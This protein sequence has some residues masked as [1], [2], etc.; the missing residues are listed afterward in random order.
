MRHWVF[1]SETPLT[2]AAASPV[3]NAKLLMAL[4]A[5]GAHLDFR[6]L[7]GLT[8]LH[9]A[10]RLGDPSNVK[11]LLSLGASPNC[12]DAQG[13]TPIYHCCLTVQSSPLVAEA[14]L[15]DYAELGTVDVHRN[16]EIHQVSIKFILIKFTKII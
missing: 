3:E 11:T 9:I 15:R 13:L 14:L 12:W 5:G 8:P 1:L 2:L 7:S 6:T 16:Q 10:A 4:V